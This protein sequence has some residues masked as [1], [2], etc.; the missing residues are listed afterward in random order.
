MSIPVET[1]SATQL[2]IHLLRPVVPDPDVQPALLP[3]DPRSSRTLHVQLDL[4]RLPPGPS[5]NFR[6]PLDLEGSLK[7]SQHSIHVDE[8][9][10]R[11]VSVEVGDGLL[12][13]A[14]EVELEGGDEDVFYGSV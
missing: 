11:D 1:R 5:P 2:L 13:R 10:D 3:S 12:A 4:A 7:V 8:G 6:V 9:V 14:G